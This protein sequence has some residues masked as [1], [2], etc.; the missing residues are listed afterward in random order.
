MEG[1]I[2]AD[3]VEA[4][5]QRF[6]EE[7]VLGLGVWGHDL[8]HDRRERLHL[9]QRLEPRRNRFDMVEQ[10][11]K[12]RVFRHQDFGDFHDATMLPSK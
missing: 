6:D 10:I 1:F 4:K 8:F 5:L 12:H 2:L 11:V 9:G 7:V 3:L